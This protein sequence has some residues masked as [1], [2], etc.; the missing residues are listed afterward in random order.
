[1]GWREE[2]SG[3]LEVGTRLSTRALPYLL[4]GGGG[5]DGGDAEKEG[6]SGVEKK[7]RQGAA[8]DSFTSSHSTFASPF[9]LLLSLSPSLS[10][11]S[12]AS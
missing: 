2:D 11:R 5:D 9:L 7:K 8:N 3:C 12:S 1:M 10:L 6:G 4:G